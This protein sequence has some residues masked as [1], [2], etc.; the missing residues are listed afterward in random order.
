MA[1]STI[2]VFAEVGERPVVEVDGKPV[3]GRV[4]SITMEAEEGGIPRL[5]LVIE[6]AVEAEARG[7]VEIAT[8][9]V[10]R[11][12]LRRAVLALDPD[13]VGEVAAGY[14]VTAGATPGEAFLQAIADLLGDG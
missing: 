10:D 1:L 2:R 5:I 11:D 9:E 14:S 12:A 3:A 6:G 7:D 4:A 8:P 13:A